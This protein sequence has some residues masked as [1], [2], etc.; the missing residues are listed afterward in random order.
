MSS[1]VM[2]PWSYASLF[3]GIRYFLSYQDQGHKCTKQR[4]KK[5]QNFFLITISIQLRLDDSAKF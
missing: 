3:T 2:Q 5:K 4:F 1:T